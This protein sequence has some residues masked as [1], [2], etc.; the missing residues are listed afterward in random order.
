V[1]IGTWRYHVAYER[2]TTVHAIAPQALA[3]I[4]AAKAMG[5]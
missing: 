5:D 4:R 2:R 3:K 1:L